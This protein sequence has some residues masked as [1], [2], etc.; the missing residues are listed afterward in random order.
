MPSLFQPLACWQCQM[1]SLL[2]RLVG[3]RFQLC[4]QCKGQVRLVE[5]AWATWAQ[6]AGAMPPKVS[7]ARSR[8]SPYNRARP[9]LR[10]WHP[11]RPPPP[12]FR[13]QTRRD[14]SR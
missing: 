3:G 9:A 10:R 5:S 6:V 8:Q 13:R 1:R 2:T 12:T 7:D 11:R 14:S 4:N